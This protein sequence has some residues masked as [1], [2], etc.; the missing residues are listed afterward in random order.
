MTLQLAERQLLAGQPI[1][2][3]DMAFARAQVRRLVAAGRRSDG[4]DARRSR[5]ARDPAARHRSAR[6]RHRNRRDVPSRPR[7][8][9]R[10]RAAARRCAGGLDDDAH[11]PGAAQPAGERR[12]LFARR[13]ADQ[14]RGSRRPP[15]RSC[16][17]PCAIADRAIAA[18]RAAPRSSNVSC[19]ARPPK[20]RAA[21][22]SVST[23]A[24]RSSSATVA[25]SASTAPSVAGAAFWIDL[26]R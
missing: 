14:R 10:G 7:G 8:A 21:W 6:G 5:A 17:S 9:R 18:G 1:Q 12:A 23:S 24:V 22:A 2:P 4:S 20:A 16:A 15:R 11:P 26:P 19:A 25:P 13:H 3:A